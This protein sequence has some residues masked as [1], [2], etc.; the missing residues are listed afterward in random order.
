ME[1]ANGLEVKIPV[2]TS[3]DAIRAFSRQQ[4]REGK[5]VALVPTMV[6]ALTSFELPTCEAVPQV[7]SMMQGYLHEGHLSL[8][9]AA[10]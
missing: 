6:H 9:Q 2:M 5:L 7:W 1:A 8:V 3:K 10:K 4:K